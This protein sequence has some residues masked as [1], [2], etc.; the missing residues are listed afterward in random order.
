MF[1]LFTEFF[2]FTFASNHLR[3]FSFPETD[4]VLWE[5]ACNQTHESF[6]T[7]YD[8]EDASFTAKV[9][10]SFGSGSSVWLGLRRN[11]TQ[12][13]WSDGAPITFSESSLNVNNGEQICEAMDNNTWR[14]F[15]CSE[16][17]PF[18]CYKGTFQN[19]LFP[20]DAA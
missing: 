14:G 16:R 10:S 3:I 5:N 1:C 7:L 8:E 11:P 13:T 9:T 17:K 12:I 2:H 6:V 19:I 15:N 20:F 4:T 18:M